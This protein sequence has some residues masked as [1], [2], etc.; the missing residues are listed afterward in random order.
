MASKNEKYFYFPEFHLKHFLFLVFF[1]FTC[2]K[3]GIQIFFELDQKISIEFIKLYIYDFGDFLSIIPLL[4][5]KKRMNNNIIKSNQNVIINVNTEK[6]YHNRLLKKAKFSLYKILIIFASIDF[7]A[8]I[9][10]V[11]FFIITT[12]KKVLLR[13]ANLN[14]TLIFSIITVI[15]CSNLLLH[16]KMYK[17]HKFAFF[18]DILCL[19]VLGA[20]DV[21]NII[22]TKEIGL[23]FIY[24]S[25]RIFSEVLYSIDDVV[26]N[27]IFLYKYYS[28]YAL[29][30]FI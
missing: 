13:R 27:M 14:S 18:I 25:V 16:T 28:I 15:I 26:A 24:L 9:S 20:N 21:I 10:S 19:I 6:S 11:I 1:L 8:Q 17:H 2:V 29:Y 30:I 7:M 12:E 22:E 23:S 4:I 3:K 5:I